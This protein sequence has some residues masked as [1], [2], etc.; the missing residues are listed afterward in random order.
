MNSLIIKMNG[1]RFSK[2]ERKELLFEYLVEEIRNSPEA[3]II[4]KYSDVFEVYDLKFLPLESRSDLVTLLMEFD[5]PAANRDNLKRI[6]VLQE[7][8][9]VALERQGHFSVDFNPRNTPPSFNDRNSFLSGYEDRNNGYKPTTKV[10]QT[11][12]IRHIGNA[13]NRTCSDFGNHLPIQPNN[14]QVEY[15][16]D[17]T[18]YAV[19][20]LVFGLLEQYIWFKALSK[21]TPVPSK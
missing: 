19:K 8:I 13:I 9:Y 16:E 15:W 5:R 17:P 2:T 14:V 7:A 10:Y 21:K 4:S 1:R 11:S 12:T 18:N 20:S 3:W 6:R